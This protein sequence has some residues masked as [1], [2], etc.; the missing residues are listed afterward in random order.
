MSPRIEL[1][2]GANRGIGWETCRQLLA[3]G[4]RVVLTSRT[5]TKGQEAAPK[6]EG[7]ATGTASHPPDGLPEIF[8]GNYLEYLEES[9]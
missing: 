6:L 5:A 8:C 4:Y 2:T 3:P 9:G 1:A 7:T